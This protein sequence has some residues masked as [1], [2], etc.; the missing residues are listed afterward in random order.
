MRSSIPGI[1]TLSVCLL[2]ATWVHGAD[3]QRYSVD[4]LSTGIAPLDTML[5]SASDLIALQSSAPVS[6]FGL[7]ARAR[8]E[9]DRLK[10]VVESFGYYQSA[11]TIKIEGLALN[12]PDLADRLT[13]LPKD[14]KAKV[15]VSIALGPLYH[16]GRVTLDGA[17]PDAAADVFS[18]KSG[19]PAVADEVLAAGS[20]LQNALQERGYAFAKVDTPV[21]YENPTEP[22]LD[23]S[24]HVDAGA[25]VTIGKI[26]IEG[27]KRVH[28]K[29]VRH[30]LTLHSGQ[31]YS[32]SAIEA[33]RRDLLTLG[34]FASVSVRIGTAVDATGG[35][36]V[37]FDCRERARHAVSVNAAYS[38]DLGGS[39]GVSW[40]DRNVFGNAEQLKIAATVLDLGGGSATSGI[41]YDVSATFTIPDFHHRD[42]SL[43]I[44]VEALNQSLEAYDQRAVTTGVTLTR[45]LS[46]VWTVSVGATTV[47]EKILQEEVNYDYTLLALPLSFAYDSTHL[48]S[49]LDDPLHGM[50]DGLTIT[51]TL[52]LGKPDAVDQATTPTPPGTTATPTLGHGDASFVIVQAKLATYF[53]L[54]ELGLTK[55][56]RTVLA[57]RAQAGF[58]LGAGE[59]SLPPDQRFYGGGSGTIRG[60]K[61]QGIGPLFPDQNPKGG[62]S[63]DAGSVELRQRF[64]T[65]WGAAAFMDGGQ[66]SDSLA[67]FSGKFALGAGAGVRYYTPI[68]PIRFDVAVP[69]RRYS[70]Q[71]VA[72]PTPH[73]I[74]DDDKFEIYIG[75]GQSF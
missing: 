52:S 59:F 44:K 26:H 20:R 74:L 66:V 43:Q 51:P 42:Q 12:S 75:L 35:V 64:G 8:G 62:I 24:F 53:D 65:D 27:L 16:L 69:T 73:H 22:L 3:P 57:V 60:Y 58:A 9:V 45:K 5:R 13:A 50:R 19:A 71:Q 40:T 68:G 10:T 1:I 39:G 17:V 36:P 56:G 14:R 55:P 6:P 4:I 15:S 47:E 48:A 37:T 61:Y 30:R 54:Q 32:S 41:G 70:V 49:P 33:A 63:I 29:L 25:R 11:V 72:T 34:P 23:V 67:P 18:L 7:I 31:Q 2:Y 46:S 38:T 21:A 28:E